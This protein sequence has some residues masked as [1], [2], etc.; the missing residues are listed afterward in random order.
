LG[1]PPT[2]NIKDQKL[3]KD[4]EI[5]EKNFPLVKILAYNSSNS[6]AKFP[7]KTLSTEINNSP[8]TIERLIENIKYIHS[9]NTFLGK[10]Q[11]LNCYLGKDLYHQIDENEH[12]RQKHIGI[13]TGEKIK[14]STGTMLYADSGQMVYTV[15]NKRETKGLK[16]LDGVYISIA[17][18]L[19]NVFINFEECILTDDN[20]M[21]FT[22]VSFYSKRVPEGTMVAFVITFL[23]YLQTKKELNLLE[24]K[25]NTTSEKVYYVD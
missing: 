6:P 25:S 4:M 16:N 22:D 15:L 12:F 20:G 18:F 5:N 8:R 1:I 14:T 9:R 19:G 21:K 17:S 13:F 11:H 10:E 7:L 2:K 3:K 23:S 24:K